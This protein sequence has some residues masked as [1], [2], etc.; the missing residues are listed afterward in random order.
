M[1]YTHDV[2]YLFPW[3]FSPDMKLLIMRGDLFRDLEIARLQVAC[4]RI[5]KEVN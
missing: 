5:Y 1:S 2:V 4:M 3:A